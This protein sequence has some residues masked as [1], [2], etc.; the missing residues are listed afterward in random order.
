MPIPYLLASGITPQLGWKNGANDSSGEP[1]DALARQMKGA[2]GRTRPNWLITFNQGGWCFRMLKRGQRRDARGKFLAPAVGRKHAVMSDSDDGLGQADQSFR[3][4]KD[5]GLSSASLPN[6]AFGGAPHHPID[7][8][9]GDKAEPETTSPTPHYPCPPAREGRAGASD[10]DVARSQTVIFIPPKKR[11][12]L[13]RGNES[14]LLGPASVTVMSN[15]GYADLGMST[16]RLRQPGRA[17]ARL[18]SLLVVGMIAVGVIGS[19]VGEIWQLAED[20]SS[21]PRV[22][23]RDPPLTQ[24]APPPTEFRAI[25]NRG[26]AERISGAVP[27]RPG[28]PNT[29]QSGAQPTEGSNVASGPT[30]LASE[31]ENIVGKTA[32]T[33]EPPSIAISEPPT[34]VKPDPAP[35]AMPEPTPVARL[36]P[37][38]TAAPEFSPIVR[39]EQ[40]PEPPLINQA[41]PHSNLDT[42]PDDQ[43]K[44]M[45]IGKVVAADRTGFVIPDSNIR[46]LARAELQRLSADRLHIARNEI[47]ARKGR[48]FKDDALRAYFSQFS[49]YRPRAWEVPLG[50]VERAN[51]SLI[52][53]IEGPAATRAVT[54]L[55][56]ADTKAE[57]A[58]AV[59]DPNSRYL[60]PEELQGLSADQ[61]AIIRNEIFARRGRYFKD[62]GLRAYFSRF[63]WYQPRAWDVPLSP[64]EQANVK[65]VQSFEQAASTPGR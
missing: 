38:P 51:V 43:A 39:P 57:N 7:H 17:M 44:E 54:G 11:Q 31:Y 2:R 22:A 59:A 10:S 48:Y 19:T 45:Q 24:A 5:E 26:E 13:P 28:V 18:T 14:P 8:T 9:S 34:L 36:E 52:Q 50:P 60:T 61:L 41:P 47:Y 37:A 64:V 49:W 30:V 56:S 6:F 12:R 1:C 58:A 53:S 21:L 23:S 35:T 15:R 62:D 4:G 42:A 3:G 20:R 63:S 29:V 16:P 40:T 65:L 33:R 46:Y 25:T 55:L 32:A 27:L